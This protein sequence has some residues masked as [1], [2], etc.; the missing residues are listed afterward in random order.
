MSDAKDTTK[1]AVQDSG[2]TIS[3][4]EV[5]AT[6]HGSGVPHLPAT[7]RLISGRVW[8]GGDGWV[9]EVGQG[10]NVRA[11]DDMYE[12][13]ADAI[14]AVDKEIRQLRDTAVNALMNG[15]VDAARLATTREQWQPP[16]LQV[17]ATADQQAPW[18]LQL[19]A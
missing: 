12:S 5:I 18:Q 11:L 3:L 14:V 16:V 17:F 9:G 10:N 1:L 2:E 8:P 7:D 15:G 13:M 6:A 19:H 4:A